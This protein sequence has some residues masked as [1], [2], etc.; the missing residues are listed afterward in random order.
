MINEKRLLNDFI[1]LVSVPAPSRDEKQVAG[2]IVKKLAEIGIEAEVDDAGIKCGGSTG[3]VWAFIPA[4]IDYKVPALFF[5]AHMDSVAPTTGTK[6][7]RRDGILYS[8]GTTTLG[9]DDKVGIAAALEAVK[10]ILENNLPHGDIQLCFTIGEEIG[11]LG[12]KNMDASRIKADIGYCLDDGNEPGYVNNAAPRLLELVVKITGKAAHAGIEPEKGINAIM[13][14]A[15]ALNALPAYGRLDEETTL[16]VGTINGGLASNIVA[17]NAGFV[18]D[19]RCLN[20]DKLENLK[21]ETIKILKETV[22][23]EGKIEIT[24]VEGAPAMRVNET[25]AGVVYVK[26]AA[27]KLGLP[28]KTFASG[29]CTDGNYLCGMGLPCIALGT[30]MK[31]IHST[32]EYLAEKDLYNLAR[33][34]VEIISTAAAK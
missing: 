7:V 31:K 17:E 9:G 27:E 18:I 8:D 15:K 29:G 3:N 5:E 13:L 10:V 26:K 28:F 30:G 1:D 21:D 2:L 32:E 6:V 12:V 11:C 24:V 14:A 22:E 33:L 16:N 34:V 4:N 23:P 25:D 19:M 20:H